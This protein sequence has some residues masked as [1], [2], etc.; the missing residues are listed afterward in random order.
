MPIL[1][2]IGIRDDGTREMQAFS[3]GDRENQAAWVD[4]VQDIQNRGVQAA[5]LR[6]TD[7]QPGSD[8]RH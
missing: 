5:D 8:Q 6:I 1:A 2:I 3:T 4:L 7:G